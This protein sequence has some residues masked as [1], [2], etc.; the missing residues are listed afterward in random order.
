MLCKLCNNPV[1]K[2]SD[3]RN[4]WEFL[5]CE[6]CEFIF[7]NPSYYVSSEDELKQYNNHNNTMD[8]P[9][10]VEMFEKFM[11]DT[12]L[13]YIE[14]IK[15]VLE[16][17]SGPGPVLSELLKQ[18]ALNVDIYDKY[19]SPQKV[20]EGKEY[21]LITSTEVIEH[22]ENPKEIFKFFASHIKSG[23]Y[24]ALMTQFHTNVPDEFKK[25]WYKNDPTHICFFRPYTFEVLAR[26]NG[27]KVLKHDSKKSVLLKK[28]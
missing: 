26:E 14:S 7:K 15:N 16:F 1:T 11:E 12:F 8:S 28:V 3:T 13:E 2:I 4:N 25:W 20:Y 24:L 19:F 6:N 18:R 17:G 27:F 22:I 5:H 9:G 21:D 23:G 10:Y